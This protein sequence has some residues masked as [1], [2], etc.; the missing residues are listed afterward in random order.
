M[1]REVVD[2]VCVAVGIAVDYLILE[3]GLGLERTHRLYVGGQDVLY[4]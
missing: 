3:M 4:H 2:I 1:D